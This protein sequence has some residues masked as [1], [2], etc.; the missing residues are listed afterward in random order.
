MEKLAA[1]AR[2]T[3]LQ[4]VA[5]LARSTVLEALRSR[6]A[7]VFGCV[8]LGAYG[9]AGFIGALALTETRQ[10]QAALL[11]SALRLVLAF[12]VAAFAAQSVVRE[13][14]DRVRDLL[15]A[16]P[17]PRHRYL[18]GKLAGLCAV[19][20]A[21]AVI[22]T[23]PLL[24]LAPTAQCLLWCT[25]LACEAGIVAGFALF[26]ASGIGHATAAL[27]ATLAFYVL[28][29]VMASIVLLAG[30]GAAAAA[31]GSASALATGGAAGGATAGSASALAGGAVS[32]TGT[33]TDGVARGLAHLLPGLDTFARTEWLVYGTG[34]AA[35]LLLCLGQAA[36]YLL[37]LLAAASFDLSRKEIE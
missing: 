10:L 22:F 34:T 21:G 5:A 14:D 28:S 9:A 33:L 16:L 4:T 11:A 13:A 35:D 15:L 8:A 23:L 29:R 36:I 6:L 7:W 27:A 37:L 17:M 32:A 24:P 20:L 2:A 30:H 18:A 25:T 12:L 1:P 26:C 31:S 3:V 19:A